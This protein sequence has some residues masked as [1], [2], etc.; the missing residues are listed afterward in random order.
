MKSHWVTHNGSR[1]I[2]CDFRNFGRDVESLRQEVTATDDEITRQPPMSVLALIDVRG[3]TT[4]IEAVEV[5]KQSAAR[6]KGYI[7]RQA[8][9]GV[10]GIQKI[11]A[12]AVA[13]FSSEELHLFNTAEEAMDWLVIGQG[14]GGVRV[15]PNVS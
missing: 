2:Y 11:L 3:T 9:I 8:V 13:R 6:S 1:I 4:S 7:I 10:A 5:F 15:P 12:Q 14:Q